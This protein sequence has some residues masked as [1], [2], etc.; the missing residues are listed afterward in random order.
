LPR[1][2]ELTAAAAQGIAGGLHLASIDRVWARDRKLDAT[3]QR[4]GVV[5][6]IGSTVT[7]RA[8]PTE[9]HGAVCIQEASP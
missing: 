1:S 4:Y 9:R 6:D 8:A 5:V 7:T 2:S 3:N